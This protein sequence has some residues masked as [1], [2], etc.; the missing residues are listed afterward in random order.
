[1][2]LIPCQ[3]AKNNEQTQ[4]G[5]I[6]IDKSN[7]ALYNLKMQKL[8]E[9]KKISFTEMY[10]Q[11]PESILLKTFDKASYK[12]TAPLCKAIIKLFQ[13]FYQVAFDVVVKH[14][15]LSLGGKYKLT[16]I[17]QCLVF[18]Q[19]NQ[20]MLEIQETQIEKLQFI[21]NN[22]LY[23]R[24]EHGGVMHSAELHTAEIAL[25]ACNLEHLL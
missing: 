7:V 15:S 10:E 2:N 21:A 19:N 11:P 12:I 8:H 1:M 14:C 25:V 22:A 5:F 13:Q 9:I 17:D 24:F 18:L 23:M 6:F 16:V 3:F 4:F 20:K